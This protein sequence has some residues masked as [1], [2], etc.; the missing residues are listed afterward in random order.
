MQ[1]ETVNCISRTNY[2]MGRKLGQGNDSKIV[3]AP[4]SFTF[5]LYFIDQDRGWS[6]LYGSF[7][8]VERFTKPER[9]KTVYY[10]LGLNTKS[11]MEL[12]TK[13]DKLNN[14]EYLLN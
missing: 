8:N 11:H 5:M 12:Q 2:L 6:E 4:S 7:Q 13:K 3:Q 9:A 10:H 1:L 14:E